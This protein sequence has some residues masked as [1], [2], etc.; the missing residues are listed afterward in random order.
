MIFEGLAVLGKL[1]VVI[2]PLK[3]LE[4][5]QVCLLLLLMGLVTKFLSQ[6]EQA[7][8][9][10][11]EA[12]VINKDTNKTA[13]L[14]KRTRRTAAMVYISPEMALSESFY[15]LWKDSHFRNCLTAIIVDEA[16]CIDEWGD[17]AFHPHYRKLNTLRNYMGYKIPIVACCGM[18]CHCSHL[19]F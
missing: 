4:R 10:E 2:S 5:D 3:A 17:D 19:N 12:I 6:A 11:I 1:V 18:Y 8:A 9:K 16:H 15:K 13:D 7:T 14:W